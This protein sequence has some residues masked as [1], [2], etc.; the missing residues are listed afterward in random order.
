MDSSNP[1][2]ID[3]D[4]RTFI[5]QFT[6]NQSDSNHT[7]GKIAFGPDGYLYISIGDGGGGGDPQ[8][9]GQ[10]LNTVLEVYFESTLI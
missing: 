2:L 3:A 5:A 9:N 8:G 6:K 10:N 7:G 4:S 1:N